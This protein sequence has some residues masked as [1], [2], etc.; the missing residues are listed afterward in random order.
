MKK[1]AL[2][3]FSGGLDSILAA[4]ILRKEKIK[5]ALVCCKSFFFDCQSAQRSARRL[6]LKLKVI[7]L[8]K[9]HLGT[10]KRPKY[11][12]GQGM[13]PC[14][15][16]HILMIKKAKEILE[17]EKLDFLATGEV[18]GERPFSQ[19]RKIFQ[20]AEKET[21]LESLILRPL[22]AKLLPLTIPEKRRWVKRENLFGFQG[23]SRKPQMVLAK[24][25]KLKK[26]PTPAGGCILTDPEYSKRLREL[27]KKA[28]EC[29]GN[30][31]QILRKGRIF[32]LATQS[33]GRVRQNRF[34]IIVGRN[35]KEN[36]QIHQLAGKKKKDLILEPQ[37]F[38]GPT[39]LIRGFGKEIKKEKVLEATALL[40]NYSKKIPE[41]IIIEVK[42]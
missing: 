13:N 42:K 25:M 8:S 17:R 3:L 9:E 19:N 5:V 34:L 40:L 39:V 15:D 2:L 4:E 16:C 18:L 14:I 26:F 27:F 29:D 28:P 37:N 33:F 20:L 11:G 30:D 38:P 22:S 6:K 36:K 35:E 12:R 7:A 24:K 10:V 21:E 32:W 41:K 31:C 1:T 23:K